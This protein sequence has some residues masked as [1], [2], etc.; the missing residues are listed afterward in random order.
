MY[1][2][3]SVPILTKLRYDDLCYQELPVTYNNQHAFVTPTTHLLVPDG[4]EVP[5]KSL[6]HPRFQ[7]GNQWYIRTP[8]LIAV[9]P[10]KKLDPNVNI[11]WEYKPFL[12]LSAGGLYSVKQL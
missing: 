6:L 12:G 1:I 8:D 4:T 7:I 10:P 2:V 11:N 3:K 5:C 9:E